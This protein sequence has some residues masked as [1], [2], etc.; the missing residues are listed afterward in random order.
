MK[1]T[2]K[3]LTTIGAIGIAAGI[4]AAPTAAS[5]TRSATSDLKY[6]YEC[7]TSICVKTI[8]T[9]GFY[10]VNSYGDRLYAGGWSGYVKV[11]TG[12]KIYF[13][14]WETI[15]LQ[16]EPKVTEIFVSRLKASWCQ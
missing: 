9:W 2:A 6:Y 3:V 13:C 4:V 7:G 5:A 12:K 11:S 10:S 14:D 1:V 15:Q 8:T 16:L